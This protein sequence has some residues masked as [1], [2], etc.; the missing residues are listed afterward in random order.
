MSIAMPAVRMRT[1]G[2]TYTW[3]MTHA[4]APVMHIVETSIIV[5]AQWLIV[6]PFSQYNLR[7]RILGELLRRNSKLYPQNEQKNWIEMH[8]CWFVR[9][10]MAYRILCIWAFPVIYCNSRPAI[11]ASIHDALSS[12]R[13]YIYMVESMV[14]FYLNHSKSSSLCAPKTIVLL[15][16]TFA[17]AIEV[18]NMVNA[19]I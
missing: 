19:W 9:L 5:F 4:N 1:I 8:T 7:E 2:S 17:P 18:I 16:Q 14:P 11:V 6:N 12:H 10:R 13:Q 3:I 15:L